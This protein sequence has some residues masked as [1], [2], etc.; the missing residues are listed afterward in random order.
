MNFL[1]A[2]GGTAGHINPALAI[3]E[4]LRK[5]VPDAGVLFIGADRDMEKRLIP[6][7]GYELVNI[8]MSGLRRGVSPGDILHNIK[9]FINLAAAGGET[10]KIIRQFMP[11]AVIGTGGYICYPVLKKGAGMGIP[12]FVHESNAVPGLTTKLLSSIVDRVLVSF[13]GIE[14]NY[15]R[16]DRV[17]FTGTPVRGGFEAEKQ[18]L[19][20]KVSN[21]KPLVL[22]F[23]GSLG[24]EHMNE[25]IADFIKI[26]A[27]CEEFD[28]IHATGSSSSKKEIKD[29]LNQI[30]APDDLPPGIEIREYIDD[31][32]SAMALADIVLCR[33]GGSTVAELT[34]MGKPAVLV[35]SPYV[36]NNEQEKNAEQLIKAGGAVML[37]EKNC[38]GEVL[39]NIV[40][41][42]LRNGDKLK[43]MLDAQK[44]LGV[45][46]AA[47]GIADL[48]IEFVTG[49]EGG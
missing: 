11:Q 42:I 28:H 43:K 49:N 1:F 18:S 27:I 29:R 9:T 44:A 46:K 24:A 47:Q 16:P 30:G 22:S 39:Y 2:C 25:T 45:P 23:W 7:A 14:K 4:E 31:M 21:E 38:S 8:K 35:P 26:N 5:R 40:T 34:A 17:V 13:P 48:I 12:T 19:I 37:E 36:S 33:A 32:Q 10:A 41:D 6:K 3:A 20:K 15:K